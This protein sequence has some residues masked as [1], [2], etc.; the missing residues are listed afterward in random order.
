VIETYF[1]LKWAWP[2]LDLCIFVMLILIYR[3]IGKL[4]L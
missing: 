1:M 4:R 3:R 2:L